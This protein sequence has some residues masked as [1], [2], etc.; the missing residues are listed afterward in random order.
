R[1]SRR[2]IRPTVRPA[3]T[4]RP[5]TDAG[6]GTPRTA[7]WRARGRPAPPRTTGRVHRHD[8]AGSAASVWGRSLPTC[9]FTCFLVG[10]LSFG[11]DPD[12]GGCLP[13]K[14]WPRILVT[15]G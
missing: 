14:L 8:T 9:P 6:P 2:P 15:S 3:P 5:G 10:G 12:Q 1:K 11:D 4:P 7:S 13:K